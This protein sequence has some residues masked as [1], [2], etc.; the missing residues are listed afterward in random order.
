[1]NLLGRHNEDRKRRRIVTDKARPDCRVF[2]AKWKTRKNDKMKKNLLPLLL[3]TL[4]KKKRE[5]IQKENLFFHFN[6]VCLHNNTHMGRGGTSRA[7][8]LSLLTIA[9]SPIP[10]EPTQREKKT[11][12][13]RSTH[14]IVKVLSSL[15]VSVCVCSLKTIK[16]FYFHLLRMKNEKQQDHS[17]GRIISTLIFD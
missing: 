9:S 16:K 4:K 1:M 15:C 11:K 6:V 2:T 7:V 14:Y 8:R 13:N 3:S 5:I 12:K 10:V 17:T